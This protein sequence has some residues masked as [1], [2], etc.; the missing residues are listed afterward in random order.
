MALGHV[1]ALLARRYQA[2]FSGLLTHL[3]SFVGGLVG[4]PLWSSRGTRLGD[5]GYRFLAG[6]PATS[7]PRLQLFQLF[8]E[9]CRPQE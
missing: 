9:E 2:G 8:F 3:G 4:S 6:A 1:A 7:R 5:T